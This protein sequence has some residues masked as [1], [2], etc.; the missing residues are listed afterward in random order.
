MTTAS[1][2]VLQASVV[3]MLMPIVPLKRCGS[4]LLFVAGAVYV[5]C[6][7]ISHQL[8]LVFS[9]FRCCHLHVHALILLALLLH[10]LF[11]FAIAAHHLLLCP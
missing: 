9:S 7:I 6:C 5:V 8:R 10:D 1:I 2:M 3:L 4:M 11:I